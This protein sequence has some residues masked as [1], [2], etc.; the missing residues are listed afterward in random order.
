MLTTKKPSAIPTYQTVN[1]PITI[2]PVPLV[3]GLESRPTSGHRRSGRSRPATAGPRATHAASPKH[4]ARRHRLTPN[5]ATDAS[6]WTP[7]GKPARLRCYRPSQHSRLPVVC[8]NPLCGFPAAERSQ[9]FSHT[10]KRENSARVVACPAWAPPPGEALSPCP[11]GAE[12]RSLRGWRRAD[13]DQAAAAGRLW[14]AAG[15]IVGCGASRPSRARPGPPARPDPPTTSGPRQDRT[16]K[17]RRRGRSAAK[18]CAEAKSQTVTLPRR[19]RSG[20]EARGPGGS[21]GEPPTPTPTSR[22]NPAAQAGHAANLPRRRRPAGETRVI[23]R[24][25]CGSA[26]QA[27]GRRPVPQ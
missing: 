15:P 27:P 20:G 26:Q 8:L 4:S 16:A 7:A 5:G 6:P 9:A 21:R 24:R 19:D 12:R 10:A 23:R 18:L 13:R 22:R 25:S 3:D 2:S 17:P 11:A 14:L 1:K